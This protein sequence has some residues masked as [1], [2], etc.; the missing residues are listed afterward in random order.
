MLGPWPCLHSTLGEG[1]HSQEL[2]QIASATVLCH[3][4]DVR[5]VL[6]DA[7]QLQGLW[8][9]LHLQQ[10]AHLHPSTLLETSAY[11]ADYVL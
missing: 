1:A 9:V 11:T 10:D 4:E 5:V 3:D 7:V 8:A 6:V 2:L